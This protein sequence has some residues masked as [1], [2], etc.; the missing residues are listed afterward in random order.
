MQLSIQIILY[1]FSDFN[2][3]QLMICELQSKYTGMTLLC[4][5]SQMTRQNVMS[6]VESKEKR[7]WTLLLTIN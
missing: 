1:F 3:E 7:C 2:Q 4:L 5:I 6:P